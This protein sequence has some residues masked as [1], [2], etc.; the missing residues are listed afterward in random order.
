MNTPQSAY[1]AAIETYLGAG[2]QA[3]LFWKGRVAL[4]AILDAL[5]LGSGD[6]IIVPALTCVAVPNAIVYRGATPVYVDVDEKMFNIDAAC[7]EAKVTTRTKAILAQNTFGLSAD[8]DE[9]ISLARKHHLWVIEDCAHGFGGTYKGKPNGTLADAAFFSTQWNKPFSTGIGGFAVIRNDALA[10]KLRVLE[11]GALP[12]DASEER[13]L[14]AQLFVNDHFL[15]Q[16]T[17]WLALYT[18]RWLSG[19]NLVT[20]SSQGEEL[21]SPDMPANFLKGAS[22]IQAKRGIQ[23][24]KNLHT[25]LVHRKKVA[26]AYKHILR[27]MGIRPPFEPDYADHTFIKFPLLVKDR[28][29]FFAEAEKHKIEIGDWFISPIHPIKTNFDRWHYRYGENPVA[30]ALCRHLINL[31]THGKIDDQY[32]ERIERF[33][34]RNSGNIFES[35]EE[36]LSAG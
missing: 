14:K 20:G 17:Y 5:G 26:D 24:L 12:P 23:E 2:T 34:K 4:Y 31:P 33:L 1:K 9:I 16:T 36:C 29:S 28:E 11:N 32:L 3:F 6:E 7:I 13:S 21:Q 18:Y 27:D 8:L 22:P 15:N 19:H 25:N 10:A 30:E 35:G